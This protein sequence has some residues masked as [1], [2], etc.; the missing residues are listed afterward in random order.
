MTWECIF[1]VFG[2]SG[3]LATT[4]NHLGLRVLCVRHY[5]WPQ[6]WRDEALCSHQS[7]TRRLRWKMS[8]RNDFT[9]TTTR[10]VLFQK[11]I[12]L[13]GNRKLASACSHA[14]VSAAPYDSCLRDVPKIQ[15]LAAQPRVA[16]AWRILFF[17]IIMQKA[18]VISG[19]K[20]RRQRYAPNCSQMQIHLHPKAF[21]SRSEF[22]SHHE[23]TKIPENTSFG[24]CGIVSQRVKCMG[25]IDFAHI[26][27]SD[28]VMDGR[29]ACYSGW[30]SMR[31]S[32][33]RHRFWSQGQIVQCMLRWRHT[34]V[35]LCKNDDVIIVHTHYF[36]RAIHTR[37][38]WLLASCLIATSSSVTVPFGPHENL[39][40]RRM[41]Q[42]SSICQYQQPWAV[43]AYRT[44]GGVSAGWLI[45]PDI[46]RRPLMRAGL[47]QPLWCGVLWVLSLVQHLQQSLLE[48]CFCTCLCVCV[49]LAVFVFPV[50]C[51]LFFWLMAGPRGAASFTWGISCSILLAW[52]EFVVSPSSYIAPKVV[53]IFFL[54]DLV[55]SVI[56]WWGQCAALLPDAGLGRFFLFRSRDL[57][58]RSVVCF[59]PASLVAATIA[60][61][62]GK[63]TVKNEAPT[64]SL[65]CGDLQQLGHRLDHVQRCVPLALHPS[66]CV[67]L[68]LLEIMSWWSCQNAPDG[69]LSSLL[70]ACLRTTRDPACRW[71]SDPCAQLGW[72]IDIPLFSMCA[73]GPSAVSDALWIPRER[74]CASPVTHQ[75]RWQCD[76]LCPK[77]SYQSHLACEAS[78]SFAAPLPDRTQESIGDGDST[79]QILPTMFPAR[80]VGKCLPWVDDVGTV[81]N[82][83]I[84]PVDEFRV[85]LHLIV[86]PAPRYRDCRLF[87]SKNIRVLRRDHDFV[88]LHAEYVFVHILH[89]LVVLGEIEQLHQVFRVV[90]FFRQGVLGELAFNECWARVYRWETALRSLSGLAIMVFVYSIRVKR[91]FCKRHHPRNYSDVAFGSAL[92]H[93]QWWVRHVTCPCSQSSPGVFRH[94]LVQA[95]HVRFWAEQHRRRQQQERQDFAPIILSARR[96]A[97]PARPRLR[98]LVSQL[99]LGRPLSQVR[100]QVTPC[101]EFL[102][103]DPRNLFA[104]N[105]LIKFPNPV[106]TLVPAPP[107]SSCSAWSLSFQQLFQRETPRIIVDG[108]WVQHKPPTWFVRC[109]FHPWST[110]LADIDVKL[111]VA[112]PMGATDPRAPDVR[113]HM[114]AFA[115][116]CCVVLSPGLRPLLWTSAPLL[117]ASCVLRIGRHWKACLCLWMQEPY[118]FR[119][120]SLSNPLPGA[121]VLRLSASASGGVF[122]LS[123]VL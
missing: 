73:I 117:L 7:S 44:A 3:F 19:R 104:W 97:Y 2:G 94:T 17:W 75:T 35:F 88:A 21:A 4:A 47:F 51:L 1:D 57:P 112:S 84:N 69:A 79:Q 83:C 99:C 45:R 77:K 24:Y 101:R 30:L 31:W 105:L 121:S 36:C 96:L 18:E 119:I 60:V 12:R 54:R 48:D 5:I 29:G 76:C 13:C 90:V 28:S 55:G 63:S 25:V 9:S 26:C 15:T 65:R 110:H 20:C 106:R 123:G 23:R 53:H 22:L 111:S 40:L 68:T 122:L 71:D 32:W 14:V 87:G 98:L 27:G 108:V 10:F 67:D 16:W 72:A 115:G 8:R 91:A 42:Q 38:S 37:G 66:L 74:N 52:A 113:H 114:S 89:Q 116:T 86:P 56:A 46:R 34:T 49:H 62:V 95:T 6:V 81:M 33:T 93:F 85:L 61:S 118:S 120:S 11:D 102:T 103:K 80:M 82:T 78:S 50:C 39:G 41:I 100:R 58:K 92:N 43:F 70:P 107:V 109:S 59:A 64:S